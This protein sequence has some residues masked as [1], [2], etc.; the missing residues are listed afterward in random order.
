MLLITVT[1]SPDRIR[2]I[3]SKGRRKENILRNEVFVE[4]FRMRGS[5]VNRKSPEFMDF[6][7]RVFWTDTL[8]LILD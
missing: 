4:R 2:P 7:H 3:T 5:G 8:R 6:H 1:Q